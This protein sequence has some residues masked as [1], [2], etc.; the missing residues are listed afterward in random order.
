MKQT[1]LTQW[2]LD[3][4]TRWLIAPDQWVDGQGWDVSPDG[5][6][7]FDWE[8]TV[9]VWVSELLEI[10]EP[11]PEIAWLNGEAIGCYCDLPNGTT[12]RCD[13]TDFDGTGKKSGDGGKFPVIVMAWPDGSTPVPPGAEGGGQSGG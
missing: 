6:T 10:P 7:R 12:Y 2:P 8:P 13:Y 1:A 11:L 5:I 3:A 4:P 9:P